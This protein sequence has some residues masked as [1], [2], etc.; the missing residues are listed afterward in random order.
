MIGTI[1]MNSKIRLLPQTLI[2]LVIPLLPNHEKITLKIEPLII[3][4]MIASS[5]TISIPLKMRSIVEVKRP[6]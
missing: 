1:T 6:I 3:N 4:G 2:F 5:G